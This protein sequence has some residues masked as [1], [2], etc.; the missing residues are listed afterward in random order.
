MF[1]YRVRDPG[2][3]PGGGKRSPDIQMACGGGLHTHP[4]IQ[5]PRTQDLLTPPSPFDMLTFSMCFLLDVGVSSIFYHHHTTLPELSFFVALRLSYCVSTVCFLFIHC[6]PANQA[7]L[8]ASMVSSNRSIFRYSS[9][10][11]WRLYLPSFPQF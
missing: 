10:P 1:R 5:E 7:L 4:R 3:A 11:S 2:T 6:P 8:S 9:H